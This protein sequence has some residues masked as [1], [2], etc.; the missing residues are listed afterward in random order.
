MRLFGRTES[1]ASLDGSTIDATALLIQARLQAASTS[2]ATI[3]AT[4]AHETAAGIIGRAFAASKPE[5]DDRAVGAL[6]PL[7]LGMLG[8]S[9]VKR[10]EFVA[11]IET[12]NGAVHLTPAS[13]WSVQ[14]TPRSWVYEVTLGGP[15][16]TET[17]SNV[18]PAQVVHCMWAVDPEQPWQGLGPLK[19]AQI[20]GRLSAEI[21][22]ALADEASAPHGNI[23]PQQHAADDATMANLIEAVASLNGATMLVEDPNLAI[24]GVAVSQSSS[25]W[26]ARRF[27]LNMPEAAIT[28]MSEA[29]AEVLNACGISTA[30]LRAKDAASARES[31]RQLLFGTIGPVARQVEHELRAKLG[32]VTL[33]FDEMRASDVQGRARAFQSM[34]GGGIEVDRA[35]ALS[36]LL[37]ED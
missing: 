5:G 12:D 19:V 8:R 22:Q 23:V 27:G 2:T 14:G 31:W 26:Q 16:E 25:V 37:I 10:G 4:A 13:S 29:T 32:D 15:S 6:S 36:G 30:V 35:A 28:L 3:D 24:G 34:V 20:A 1:R 9:L 11:L 17:M 21:A 18:S 33:G 7:L